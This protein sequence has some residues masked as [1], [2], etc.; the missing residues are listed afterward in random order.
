[1]T[2]AFRRHYNE[3]RPNHALSCPGRP[4]LVVFPDLP[5]RPP[6]PALVDPDRWLEA[7]DGRHY[8]RTVR[9]NGTVLLETHGYYVSRALAGQRVVLAVA[10]AQRTLVVRHRQE[11]VRRLPLKGLHGGVLPFAAYAELMRQEA[12][13]RDRRQPPRQVA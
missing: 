10:A 1:M 4:P 7:A 5:S 8:V 13:A 11:E 12:R 6:V 9:A 3:E 2:T